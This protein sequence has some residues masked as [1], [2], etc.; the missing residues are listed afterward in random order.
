MVISSMPFVALADDAL[1]TTLDNPVVGNIDSD[2]SRI[3]TSAK[4]FNIVN[5]GQDGNFSIGFW[6]YDI[7]EITAMGASATSAPLTI[8]VSG[9]PMSD[10]QGLTFY[11]ATNDTAT[12]ALAAGNNR[13]S[14]VMGSDRGHLERASTYFGLQAIKSYSKDYLT[15]NSSF[16][17][18]IS[19]AINTRALDNKNDLTIMVLQTQAGGTGGSDWTDTVISYATTKVDVALSL[20]LGNEDPGLTS[21]KKAISAYEAKMKNNGTD[22]VLV[23]KNML[24]AY[25]AYIKACRYRDAYEYGNNQNAFNDMQVVTQDLQTKTAQM[26]PWSDNVTG[27]YESKVPKFVN[28][29]GSDTFDENTYKDF[30]GNIIYTEDCKSGN[31]DKKDG[32]ISGVSVTFPTVADTYVWIYYPNTILL[33]D[34]SAKKPIMPAMIQAK[35]TVNKN[36]YI[37]AVYP[38]AAG[39]DS[40]YTSKCPGNNAEF[41]SLAYIKADSN[42][43][44]RGGD[45]NNSLDFNYGRT[46]TN[47]FWGTRHYAFIGSSS[48]NP[49][50]RNSYNLGYSS[51]GYWNHYGTAFQVTDAIKFNGQGVKDLDPYWVW[52]GGST[53]GNRNISTTI[54]DNMKGYQQGAHK[55]YVV[56]Y[57]GLMDAVKKSTNLSKITDVTTYTEGG[58]AGVMAAYDSATSFDVN[59]ITLSNVVAKGEVITNAISGIEASTTADANTAAYKK[60]KTSMSKAKKIYENGNEDN[61]NYTAESWAPFAQAYEAALAHFSNL[62]TNN[63]NSTTAATLASPIDVAREALVLN[64]EVVDTT[65]LEYAIDN[66]VS[67][68][69]NQQYLVPGTVNQEVLAGIVTAAKTEIWGSEEN[70]GLDSEKIA[71]TTE[72]EAKVNSYINQLVPEVAKAKINL[73]AQTTTGYSILSAIEEARSYESRSDDYGN[74]AT[75]LTARSNAEAFVAADNTFNAR[76]ENQAANMISSYVNLIDA[77]DTAIITLRPSFR[78]TTNGTVANAGET[79]TTNVISSRRPNN[80]RFSWI[81]TSGIVYFKT[82]DEKCNFVLPKSTW[83]SYNVQTGAEFYTVLDS[84]N[85]NAQDVPT[86]ELTNPSTGG[87]S[88]YPSG[89]ELNGDQI[90]EHPGNLSIINSSVGLTLNNFKVTKASAYKNGIGAD[91]SGNHIS[92]TNHDFTDELSTTEGVGRA[93][94]IYALNGTT[95]FTSN[96]IIGAPESSGSLGSKNASPKSSSK[97]LDLAGAGTDIGILYN[98][99][100]AETLVVNWMG[101]SFDKSPLNLDV[102]IVNVT[103]LFALI[104]DCET[105]EFQAKANDYTTGS[106]NTLL[107][108]VSNAKSNLRE[109]LTTYDEIVNECESR[110]NA[111]VA[112]RN[113]LTLSAN[114][115]KLEAA[116]AA[117]KSA[118]ENDQAKISAAT[119][120][121]FQTAYEEALAKYQG[122]YSDIGV[123]NFARTEQSTIDS[124]ATA[125]TNAFNAL[126]YQIDFS[127]VDTAVVNLINSIANKK[128]TATSVREFAEALTELTYYNMPASERITHYTD[129][130]ATLAALNTEVNTTIPALADILVAGDNIDVEALD[131][132]KANGKAKLADPDAF[133]QDSIEAALAVLDAYTDVVVVS[134]NTRKTI[135]CLKYDTQ[136]EVDTAVTEALSDVKTQQYDVYL[137]DVKIGTYDY[138]TEITV[139][140]ND[141]IVDWYYEAQSN[142]S[143][144]PKK[145]FSTGEE[146][147]FVVKGLTELTTV[148]AKKTENTYKVT[149]VND[150][151]GRAYDVQYVAEGTE[152]ALNNAPK[153]AYYVNTGYRVNGVEATSVTVTEDTTVFATYALNATATYSVYVADLSYGLCG[154]ELNIGDLNYND[155]ISFYEGDDTEGNEGYYGYGV[156][157]KLNGENVRYGEEEGRAM[158]DGNPGVYAWVEVD[159]DDMDAWKAAFANYE[160]LDSAHSFTALAGTTKGKVVAYGK[161]YT[162][163]IS[164]DVTLLALDEATYQAGVTAGVIANAGDENGAKVDTQTELVIT[165]GRKFSM[166]TTFTLPD[167][168]K[169]VETGVLFTANPS[170]STAPAGKLT[171][172]NVGTNGIMRIKSTAHTAGNQ[173]VISITTQDTVLTGK[174]VGDVGMKWAGYMTYTDKDG[175]NHTVYSATVTPSNTDAKF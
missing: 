112:A 140:S 175:N 159:A 158:S 110:Y 116:L 8:G 73:S 81:H 12:K 128:Y 54:D 6:K 104:D 137:D 105:A 14:N 13:V 125:L 127:V 130:A 86:A 142:T 40:T 155:E 25:N 141:G 153:L 161:D 119:W 18:D 166:I 168:C 88:N 41:Q 32:D 123:R 44:W 70:Y 97:H 87:T 132:A 36:R 68:L 9:T 77:I 126:A 160:I 16:T 26:T 61:A 7:S 172:G 101:Y 78:K 120:A 35:R 46:M 28:N 15:Q 31:Y 154:L 19:D 33:Y 135:S 60:L 56:N 83:T 48:G 138:G 152:L 45:G 3:N 76:I 98:W 66:A 34:G 59:S 113:G 115:T 131:A 50:G 92:D 164:R 95:E 103:G 156:S 150:V 1:S 167:D 75:L 64:K 171:L 99:R 53:E 21:L 29:S 23:Y 121:P 108:A 43:D 93:G 90:A 133:D 147:T 58:L 38:A 96:A 109:D 143:T 173:Y 42:Y 62:Y 55:I 169:M 84:I 122:D 106:W 136:D 144:S 37:Y 67:I 151:N 52:Y 51:G 145:Y 47:D 163:R 71:K 157:Y 124:Y 65:V 72:N 107:N 11:F 2:G 4:T 91:K 146:V 102:G 117:A 118:Y 114:N 165:E 149:F 63:F 27:K 79:V 94:G 69:A 24:P 174:K 100:Y 134:K 82:T 85:L 5:D 74:Y 30:Y 129:E 139:P 49:N 57:K 148:Q 10:C 111:L 80:F 162:F 39:A 17:V 170:S 22:S 20:D 89:Y